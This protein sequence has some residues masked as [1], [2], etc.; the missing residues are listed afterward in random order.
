MFYASEIKQIISPKNH[1]IN[2]WKNRV[3]HKQSLLNWVKT[4]PF[5]R[6]WQWS[7]LP[8]VSFAASLYHT[9]SLFRVFAPGPS[10]VT[11]APGPSLLTFAP[12]PSLVTYAHEPSL[13]TFASGPS[14]LTFAPGPSLVTYAPGP[15]LVTFAPGPS[16]VTFA[17]GPSLVTFAPGPSLIELAICIEHHFS[18][19]VLFLNIFETR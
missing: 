13:V 1:G 10:L 11:F 3:A 4:I 12:G 8:S 14:R 6:M 19:H 7:R 5:I 2:K 16:L 18:T 15:S 17:P 9:E